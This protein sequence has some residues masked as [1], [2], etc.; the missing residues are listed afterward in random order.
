MWSLASATVSASTMGEDGGEA[1]L[2]GGGGGEPIY[3]IHSVCPSY[4]G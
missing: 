2:Y 4:I 1:H 3:I